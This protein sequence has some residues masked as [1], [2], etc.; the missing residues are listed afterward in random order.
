MTTWCWLTEKGLLLRTGP[1]SEVQLRTLMYISRAEKLLINTTQQCPVLFRRQWISL[2][3]WWDGSTSCLI[4][5]A[6]LMQNEL[7][8]SWV[9][10]VRQWQ[11]LLTLSMP[12][13]RSSA[14]FRFVF[15][16]PLI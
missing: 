4:T 7:L 14:W 9:Q 5:T 8:L 3:A 15:T 2:Q 11:A 16:G 10:A 1:E 13:A 12:K 6:H